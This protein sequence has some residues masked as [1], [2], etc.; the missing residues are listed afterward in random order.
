[1]EDLPRVV[2]DQGKHLAVIVCGRVVYDGM[3]HFAGRDG[4]VDV[5]KEGD[6]LAMAMTRAAAFED[7]ALSEHAGLPSSFQRG[8]GSFDKTNN[9]RS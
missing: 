9:P 2:S 7:R 4:D 8:E 1:M 6:E 3:G 5:V